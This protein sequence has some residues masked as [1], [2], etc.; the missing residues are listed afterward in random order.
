VTVLLA[1]ALYASGRLFLGW[2]RTPARESQTYETEK[3]SRV[4]VEPVPTHTGS[5]TGAPWQ[6][7][8]FERDPFA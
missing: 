2:L 6:L 7:R 3:A 1:A 5:K 4:S 8:D